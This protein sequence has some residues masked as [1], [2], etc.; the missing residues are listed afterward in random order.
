MRTAW[1]LTLVVLFGRPCLWAANKD[2]GQ[3]ALRTKAVEW[4]KTKT[5]YDADNPGFAKILTQINKD[6]E[7]DKYFTVAFGGDLM[8]SGKANLAVGFAGEFFVFELTPKRARKL[9][10]GD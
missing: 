10:L 1:V 6:I 2:P 7:A 5:H 3:A 4:V 8:K 9:H